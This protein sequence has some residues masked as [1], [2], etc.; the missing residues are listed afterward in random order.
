MLREDPEVLLNLIRGSLT[1]GIRP[2]TPS[3]LTSR[4]SSMYTKQGKKRPQSAK[5]QEDDSKKN[6]KSAG[7]ATFRLRN[8]GV[9]HNEPHWD[10]HSEKGEKIVC[11]S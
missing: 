4:A 3:G 5:S 10:H 11:G 8:Q 1:Q 6:R 2:L 9:S 7:Y